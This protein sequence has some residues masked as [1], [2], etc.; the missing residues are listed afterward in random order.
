MKTLIQ[1][2]MDSRGPIAVRRL[3]HFELR[4]NPSEWIWFS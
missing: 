1:I 4:E 3:F 2:F